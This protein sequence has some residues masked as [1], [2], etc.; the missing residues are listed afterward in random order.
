VD[1]H[2][3]EDYA[4][5]QTRLV[6]GQVQVLDEIAM[7]ARRPQP[8][9]RPGL[10][11][12]P[13]PPILLEGDT[14]KARYEMP[15]AVAMLDAASM[16]PKEIVKEALSEYFLYTIEGTENL[17]DK[18][19]KRLPSFEADQVPVTNLYKFEEDKYSTQVVRFLSFKNDA[20][21]DLGQT[22]IPGGSIQVFRKVDDQARLTY[23]GRSE[24]KYIPVGQEVEL[25]LGSVADVTVEPTLM[26]QKTDRY[27]FDTDGDISG[28]DDIHDYKVV[29]KNT[30]NVAVRVEVRRNFPVAQWEL[31]HKGDAGTYE[32]VDQDTVQFTLDLPPRSQKT[33]QYTLTLHQGQRAE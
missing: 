8:Y 3:G 2:S 1:N 20:A 31:V 29:V 9:G 27:M 17:V 21:H 18:T 23:E 10:L 4:N 13:A 5:A 6:V 25:N 15:A 32:K 16:Q 22:P 30:R 28:Y 12:P 24:F 26:N 19:A 14:S 7:L 11:P 33:F